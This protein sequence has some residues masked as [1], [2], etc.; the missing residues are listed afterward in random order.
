MGSES[1]VDLI[2]VFVETK[3][4][5]RLLLTVPQTCT[6]NELQGTVPN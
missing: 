2:K 4:D 5:T 1:S 6:I 3:L